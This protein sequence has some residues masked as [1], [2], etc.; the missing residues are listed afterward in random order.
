MSPRV[1]PIAR[2]RP[3]RAP[4]P[5]NRIPAAMPTLVSAFTGDTPDSLVD[6]SW[7]ARELR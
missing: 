1:P 2:S 5:A 3:T 6:R 4:A 7:D